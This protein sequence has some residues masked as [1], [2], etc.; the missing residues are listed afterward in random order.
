M[1]LLFAALALSAPIGV[2]LPAISAPVP[3]SDLDRLVAIMVPER[4]MLDI[5]TAAARDEAKRNPQFANDPALVDFVLARMK[6][7]ID[8]MVRDGLPELRADLAR[9]IAADL[10]PAEIAEVYTFFA[11]PTGQKLQAATYQALAENPSGDP[12]ERQRVA[13]ER[14][15]ADL[16]PG[17]YPALTAFAASAGAR[18]MQQVTPRI[19]AASKAWAD[20]LIVRNAGRLTTL[21][22]AAVADYKKG[23]GQ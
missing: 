1:K 18:K 8:K 13:V 4:A 19:A 14:F 7:D 2:A 16:K 15:M 22:N 20:R 5:V 12:A 17:D 10:T 21:R 6:P 9:V 3:V 11:S 23:T